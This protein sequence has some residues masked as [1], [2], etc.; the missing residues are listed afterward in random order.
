VADLPVDEHPTAA[1]A[2]PHVRFVQQTTVRELVLQSASLLRRSPLMLVFGTFVTV[3]AAIPLL[4]GDR[5]GVIGVLL[6]LSFL[7]GFFVVPFVWWSVRQRRD[8]LLAP[9]TVELDADGVTTTHS[10]ATAHQAWSVYKRARETPSTFI[11]ETGVSSAAVLLKRAM[12]PTDVDVVRGLLTRAG[13]LGPPPTLIRRL[14]PAIWIGVGLAAAGLLIGG[15]AFL[16]NSPSNVAIEATPTVLGRQV[17][18]DGT[19]DLPDGTVLGVQIFQFD[20]WQRAAT[21]GQDATEAFDLIETREA[22]VQGGRFHAEADT[23]G[24]PPGRGM[25]AVY[26]WIDESQP[27]AVKTRFGRDGSGLHGSNVHA[28]ATGPTFRIDRPFTIPQ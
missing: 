17:S 1:V 20:A 11:L 18:V 12:G 28:E 16:A 8:L 23:T 2:G 13:L 5:S 14:R 7:T 6:G 9:V 19:T 21:A 26:F 4:A 27:E 3:T 24:W 15:A 10:A 22:I 25:A